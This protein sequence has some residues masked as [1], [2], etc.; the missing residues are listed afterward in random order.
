ML[1]RP[2]DLWIIH[3]QPAFPKSHKEGNSCWI[4]ILKITA[5]DSNVDSEWESFSSIIMYMCK[6][7]GLIPPKLMDTVPYTSWEFLI[8]SD[9]HK[10][11]FELNL[12]TGISSKMSLELQE[13]DSSKSYSDG[14]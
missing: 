5:S 12:I 2:E 1:K 4:T 11:Y 13:S 8:N 10:N 3:S 9:L 7:S 14:G 6:K